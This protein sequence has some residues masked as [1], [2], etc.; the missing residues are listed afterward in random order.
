[1]PHGYKKSYESGSKCKYCK[2]H[3]NGDETEIIIE[4]ARKGRYSATVMDEG[5]T[6]NLGEFASKKAAKTEAK[7]FMRNNPKGLN[8]GSMGG[9][10]PGSDTGGNP[11][12]L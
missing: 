4:K 7:N 5:Q 10:I 6:M 3:R 9:M 12:G 1:M 8:G 11:F 2:T